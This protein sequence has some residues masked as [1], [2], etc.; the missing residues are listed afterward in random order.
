MRRRG[1]FLVRHGYTPGWHMP[2]GGVEAGETVLDALTR[3]CA[4]EGNIV[5]DEPPV[6]H[7]LFH[8]RHA[9]SRDHVAVYVIRRFHQTAERPRDR[10]ILEARF[11]KLD[12][13]PDGVTPGT[14][15]RL[16]RDRR[17]RRDLGLV[18]GAWVG[19]IASVRVRIHG[20]LARA[21]LPPSLPPSPLSRLSLSPSL[22]HPGLRPGIQAH[23]LRAEIPALRFAPA[24]MTERGRLDE[25]GELAG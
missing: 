19:W 23:S 20:F 5:F 17:N 22:R 7:G 1:V 18:V 24:G 11:F 6:L 13:L 2:G 25:E 10:E 14:L 12:S 21:G 3:E 15:A 9:S 4:E 16:A 8:N